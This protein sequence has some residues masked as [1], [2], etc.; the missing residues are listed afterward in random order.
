MRL[1]VII[2]ILITTALFS[3]VPDSDDFSKV[4]LADGLFMPMELTVL[5]DGRVLFLEREGTVSIYNP[6]TSNT[7]TAATINIEGRLAPNEEDGLLGITSD[8]HFTENG[9]VYVFYSPSAESKQHVSRFSLVNDTLDMSSEII[10]LEIPVTP[11]SCCHSAGSLT[12]GADSNLYISTGDDTNPFESNGFNPIDER[13]GRA[14]FDAQR[15]AGNT[16]DLRGKI[17]RITPQADG[18]YTIPEGNLFADTSVGYPEIYIMGCRNPF[19]I[20]VDPLTGWLYWGDVGPDAGSNDEARG[21]AGH[22]EWNQATQAGFYGW[23]YF[24]ADNKVY[25]DYDFEADTSGFQFDLENPMNNSPNNTGS[26]QLPLPQGA[27]IWYTYGFSEQF[28]FLGGG[29]R[30]S[31]AGPVYHFDSTLASDI[32]L[33]AYFDKTLFIYEW[34]RQFIAEIKMDEQGAIT[35]GTRLFEDLDIRHPIDMELGPDGAIYML[36]WGTGSF[37]P[38]QDGKLIRIEY[39]GEVDTVINSLKNAK[40]HTVSF[41]LQQAYPNPF[42]PQTIIKYH[43]GSESN[44]TLT[45]FDITGKMVAKLVD[46]KQASG[47]YSVL[48]NGSSLTSGIY[49]YR[50]NAGEFSEVK[51]MLLIK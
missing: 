27:W 28:P 6:Q 15:S 11:N 24:I 32:K 29:G 4:T 17:L 42:N 16:K 8:P 14:P 12:F 25:V 22:D 5:P 47:D 31:M 33:P 50:L 43:I 30:T 13:E 51:R 34:S 36:E 7:T 39:H 3:Q 20:S 37:S 1:P 26:T 23:P 41:Q 2:H 21:P 46:K 48:F 10:V 35:E 19:R 40:N 9:W 45:V 38:S 49:F 44:V 18:G